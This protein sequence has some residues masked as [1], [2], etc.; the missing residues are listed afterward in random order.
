MVR[1][2]RDRYASVRRR[3]DQDLSRVGAATGRWLASTRAGLRNAATYPDRYLLVRYEDLVA[4]PERTLRGVCAHVGLEFTPAMLTLDGLPQLRDR[5]G[6]SSFGDV[7]AGAISTR[8]VGRYRQ[9]VR[10]GELAFIQLWSRREL[11]RLGYQRV[12]T[13]LGLRL[14]LRFWL[15]DLPVD[16]A[17]MTAFRLAAAWTRRRGERVPA[18]RLTEECDLGGPR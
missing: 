12:D 1:D 13:G 15:W 9:A 11:R 2:P 10:P 3:N 14:R 16:S 7:E 18:F 8:A 5:G 6:N 4:D 17:R